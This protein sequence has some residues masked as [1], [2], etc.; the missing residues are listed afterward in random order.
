MTNS[1]D[2]TD[3][4]TPVRVRYADT[5]QMGI[6]YNGVYLTWFEIGRTELL[7]DCG[8]TYRDVEKMGY[9]LPLTEAGVKYMKPARYD[10]VIHIRTHV[11][12]Q[13]AVRIRFGYEISREDERLATGFT[14]H[15]FTDT[16]LRPTRPPDILSDVHDFLKRRKGSAKDKEQHDG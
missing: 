13:T 14:E 12:K 5:D 16:S 1:A 10:D 6:A 3:N 2:N 8:L 9:H 11:E 15:V 7:R 4:D